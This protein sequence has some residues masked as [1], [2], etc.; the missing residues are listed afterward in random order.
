MSTL[1]SGDWYCPGC[2]VLFGNAAEELQDDATVL[3][4]HQG[5]PY[6][7]N[8]LLSYVRR[9][10]DDYVLADLVARPSVA[11]S[12]QGQPLPGASQAARPAA[13]VQA[14]GWARGVVHLSPFGA[15][16]GFDSCDALGLHDA[17]SHAGVNQTVTCLHQS[18]NWPG[19][20][21]D[22]VMFSCQRRKLVLP[23]ALPLQR[24]RMQGRFKQVHT[25]TF[26]DLLTH[27]WWMCMAASLCWRWNTSPRR[28]S[29]L[30][31][32][33]G[34]LPLWDAEV[35]DRIWESFDRNPLT[36]LLGWTMCASACS[37]NSCL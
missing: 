1:A 33:T 23:K 8:V 27:L 26:V 13:C 22:V 14:Q 7:D 17:L 24:P 32:M 19:M 11:I 36:G 16:L 29:L 9:G 12:A 15:P 6:V 4:Y 10:H 3:S 37:M 35:F 28:L 18:F 30:W 34:A 25:S 31:C 20:Q 5:D 2:D 21:A